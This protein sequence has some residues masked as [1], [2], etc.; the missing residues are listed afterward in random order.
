M[1]VIKTAYEKFTPKE[2][3]ITLYTQPSQHKDYSYKMI[4]YSVFENRWL[5][6][7][8]NDIDNTETFDPDKNTKRHSIMR[9]LDEGIQ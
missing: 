7:Y 1:K 3:Y 8:Q 9:L 6:D 4:I 2:M 5:L